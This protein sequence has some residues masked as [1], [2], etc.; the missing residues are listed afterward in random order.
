MA[1]EERQPC[2]VAVDALA[3]R[4]LGPVRGRTPFVIQEV[5]AGR[6]RLVEQDPVEIGPLGGLQAAGCLGTPGAHDCGS[7]SSLAS[8]LPFLCSF[9]LFLPSL[10][11]L[12]FGPFLLD[13]RPSTCSWKRRAARSEA[14][15]L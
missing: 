7:F 13:M 5:D 4:H 10:R 12:L 11:V 9:V 14:K 8:I 6:H 2:A 1:L 3:P 15:P